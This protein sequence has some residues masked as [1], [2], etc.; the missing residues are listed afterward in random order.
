MSERESEKEGQVVSER[1]RERSYLN[2][3]FMLEKLCKYE[4]MGE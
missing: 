1:E 4:L 2:G 3:A